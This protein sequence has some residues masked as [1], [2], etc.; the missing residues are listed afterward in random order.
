MSNNVVI[1]DVTYPEVEAIAVEDENGK[2]VHYYP[3]AVRYNEQSLEESKK[4]QA[5]K[6]IGLTTETWTF[7][8]EDGSTVTKKVVLT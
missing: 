1:N 2:Q 6:N 5:R 7:T 8:L 3:D 4:A